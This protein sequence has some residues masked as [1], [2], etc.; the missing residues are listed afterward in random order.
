VA[1]EATGFRAT[2]G[3]FQSFGSPLDDYSDTTR[4]KRET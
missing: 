2:F 3:N 4:G 1:L